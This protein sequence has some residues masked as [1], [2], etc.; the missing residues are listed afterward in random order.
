MHPRTEHL[1]TLRDGGPVA[2]DVREHVA[3]CMQCG[4]EKTKGN[5]SQPKVWSMYRE[6]LHGC[7]APVCGDVTG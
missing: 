3:V 7:C 1:L 6:R 4:L 5:A 2:V